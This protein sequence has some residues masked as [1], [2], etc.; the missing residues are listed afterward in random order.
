WYASLSKRLGD[1]ACLPCRSRKWGSTLMT[2]PVAAEADVASRKNPSVQNTMGRRMGYN[3]RSASAD[4]T[5]NSVR[6]RKSVWSRRGT[7]NARC[8]AGQS[9]RGATKLDSIHASCGRRFDRR[10]CRLHGRR[11]G[12]VFLLVEVAE[13]APFQ[14]G[15]YRIGHGVEVGARLVE[16]SDAK[17]DPGEVDVHAFAFDVVA[18]ERHGVGP[19]QEG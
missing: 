2:R 6:L 9:R 5:K 11:V 13:K 14:I 19:G 12:S 16:A 4:T 7:F 15:V 8:S 10:L 3:Y 17:L 18:R 1:S